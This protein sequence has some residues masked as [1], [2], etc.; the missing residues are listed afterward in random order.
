MVM[1][2]CRSDTIG[3]HSDVWVEK[4]SYEVLKTPEDD[5]M[6]EEQKQATLDL[7]EKK[8]KETLEE[9]LS[10]LKP[11]DKAHVDVTGGFDTRTNLSVLLNKELNLTYG[12][13]VNLKH[14]GK[15]FHEATIANKIRLDITTSFASSFTD[16]SRSA[17]AC[18]QPA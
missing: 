1:H 8:S 11:N 5:E 7:L 2:R 12:S 14:K 18:T 13:C 3:E 6:L 4:P 17:F 15:K 10:F 9:S 16:D